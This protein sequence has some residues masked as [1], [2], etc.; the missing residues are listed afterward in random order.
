M[1]ELVYRIYSNRLFCCFAQLFKHIEY[2][3]K[4]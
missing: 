2:F 4:I 1:N 3:I